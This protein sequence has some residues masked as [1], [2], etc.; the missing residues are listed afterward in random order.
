MGGVIYWTFSLK[1]LNLQYFLIFFVSLLI[2]SHINLRK[3]NNTIALLLCATLYLSTNY[4][5]IYVYCRNEYVHRIIKL[6]IF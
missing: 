6:I 2:E 5:I 1:E 4:A 3:E